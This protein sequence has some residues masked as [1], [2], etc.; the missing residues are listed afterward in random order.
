VKILVDI[1]TD[2]EAM[3]DEELRDIEYSVETTI[4][5]WGYTALNVKAN[6]VEEK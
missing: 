6:V 1:E 5:Q 2:A 4:E 3:D